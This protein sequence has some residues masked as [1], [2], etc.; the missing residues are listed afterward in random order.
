MYADDLVGVAYDL[1]GLRA[2]EITLRSR[3]AAHRRRGARWKHHFP[4]TRADTEGT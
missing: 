1:V 4:D 2:H 3:P